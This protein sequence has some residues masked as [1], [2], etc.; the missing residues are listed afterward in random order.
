MQNR[1]LMKNRVNQHYPPGTHENYSIFPSR[2]LMME[3]GK[4]REGSGIRE[5]DSDN[6]G[7]PLE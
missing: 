1:S 6:R 7:F 5:V 4:G 2:N 3:K